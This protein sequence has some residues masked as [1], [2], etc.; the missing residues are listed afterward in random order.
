LARKQKSEGGKGKKLKTPSHRLKLHPISPT[1]DEVVCWGDTEEG[2]P[3]TE[4]EKQPGPYYSSNF[5]NAGVGS[6]L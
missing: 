2:L 5:K 3:S 6:G 4:S 1:L